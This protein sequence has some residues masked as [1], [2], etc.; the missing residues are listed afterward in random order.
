MWKQFFLLLSLFVLLVSPAFATELT[1]KVLWIYDGDTLKVEKIGKVRL[2]GIDTPEYKASPRD[3]FYKQN[4]NIEAKKLRKIARQGK[5]YLISKVKGKRVRL[6]LDRT[7][8]DKYNRLL[9]YVYLP[10]GEML[11]LTLLKKGLAT[12]FRRYDFQYKQAF[13]KTEKKAQEKALGLWK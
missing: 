11:N 5:N 13:L 7:Q 1:G 3:Q 12:V 6:E 9:A 8:K 10:D 4:F 2:L